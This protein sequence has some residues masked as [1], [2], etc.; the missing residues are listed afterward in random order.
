MVDSGKKT[1]R[2]NGRKLTKIVPQMNIIP[3]I[4]ANASMR[5][6]LEHLH[7]DVPGLHVKRLALGDL[8]RPQ[9]ELATHLVHA[10]FVLLTMI[11]W[12]IVSAN[13]CSAMH[14]LTCWRKP[15]LLL[16]IYQHRLNNVMLICRTENGPE[17]FF[18]M[19]RTLILSYQTQGQPR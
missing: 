9:L 8:E 4:F 1:V 6:L 11:G 15:D 7:V 18:P 2:N 5:A 16:Y 17:L 13:P 19:K 10:V 3:C 12:C 14:H